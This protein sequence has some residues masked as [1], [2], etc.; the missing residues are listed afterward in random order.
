MTYT[1]IYLYFCLFIGLFV[2]LCSPD[3]GINSVTC[4]LIIGKGWPVYSRSKSAILAVAFSTVRGKKNCR[5]P[6]ESGRP[7]RAANRSLPTPSGNGGERQTPVIFTPRAVLDPMLQT[8]M[9][10]GTSMPV[11]LLHESQVTAARLTGGDSFR[12]LHMYALCTLY[13]GRI[14]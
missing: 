4:P 5:R 9:N 2:C 6:A 13:T 1:F 7:L 3:C 11:I 10:P 14:K 12:S 8:M